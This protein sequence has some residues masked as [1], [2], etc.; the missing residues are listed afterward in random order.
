[1]RHPL[2]FWGSELFTQARRVN[3]C[4]FEPTGLI[5]VYLMRPDKQNDALFIRH[6]L[7]YKPMWHCKLLKVFV[8]F[9]GNGNCLP[10]HHQQTIVYPDPSSEHC[11]EPAQKLSRLHSGG[12]RHAG[13]LA[14]RQAAQMG[15]SCTV[16]RQN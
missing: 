10:G 1:M 9:P 2:S 5:I 12:L 3:D 11:G 16:G 15:V 4:L 6:T 14:K 13:V 8:C 7:I